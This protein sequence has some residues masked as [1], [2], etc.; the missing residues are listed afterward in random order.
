MFRCS[1]RPINNRKQ[2]LSYIKPFPYWSKNILDWKLSIFQIS[3][4]NRNFHRLW[5][6]TCS[7]KKQFQAYARNLNNS[8]LNFISIKNSFR[9]KISFFESKTFIFY[10]SSKCSHIIVYKLFQKQSCRNCI[11]SHFPSR[12]FI[13]WVEN[14]NLIFRAENL[15]SHF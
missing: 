11:L 10:Y 12:I 6:F 5:F 2:I 14:F 8:I 15:N 7:E 4:S 13:S 9:G 3:V 1:I